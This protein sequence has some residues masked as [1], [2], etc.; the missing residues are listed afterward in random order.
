[1]KMCAVLEDQLGVPPQEATTELYRAIQEG[2]CS[3][4][5]GRP[6]CHLWRSRLASRPPAR[7]PSFLEGEEPVD[8]PVFVAREREL[9]QLAGFLDSALAGQGRWSLSP[10]TP[11]VARR[12]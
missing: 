10:A 12:P 8:R 4:T 1:M 11:A 2:P 3:A 9:A 7:P 5:G 6:S